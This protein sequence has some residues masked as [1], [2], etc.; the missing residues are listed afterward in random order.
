[1]EYL[2]QVIARGNSDKVVHNFLVQLYV[3]GECSTRLLDFV[4]Q[5]E[6]DPIFDVQY[7]LRLCI[8]H[9]LLQPC[10]AL[11]RILH[12]EKEAVKLALKVCLVNERVKMMVLNWLYRF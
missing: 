4:K 3:N 6:H 2:E 11:Y 9:N 8:H 12:M 7:A 5:F 10:V 1:M